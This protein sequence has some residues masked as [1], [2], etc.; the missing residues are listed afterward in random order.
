MAHR[1]IPS[2]ECYHDHCYSHL[3]Q[4]RPGG[5]DSSRSFCPAHDDTERSLSVS[6]GKSQV[7]WRCHADCSQLA[8]RAALIRNGMHPDCLPVPREQKAEVVDAITALYAQGLGA[9]ELR[10]R[11]YSLVQGFGGER[12]SRRRY[13]GGLRGF[14][15]DAGVSPSDVYGRGINR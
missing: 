3:D 2:R 7:V 14:A 15:R 9:A 13:P 11:I 6:A 8:V 4:P 1:D 12:P 10:W 5:P